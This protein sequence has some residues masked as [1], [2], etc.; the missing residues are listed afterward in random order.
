MEQKGRKVYISTDYGVLLTGTL[1]E[2]QSKLFV[3]CGEVGC[4]NILLLS[5][6]SPKIVF[7]IA[8]T[9]MKFGKLEN[10]TE[11]ITYRS[12]H[13]SLSFAHSHACAQFKFHG[14]SS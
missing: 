9:T 13:F 1:E 11:S 7:Q 14:P 3:G 2:P 5:M 12:H 6:L 4:L 8:I 10:L